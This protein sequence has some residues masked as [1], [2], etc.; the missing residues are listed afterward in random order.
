MLFR[1]NASEAFWLAVAKGDVVRNDGMLRG[2][3]GNPGFWGNRDAWRALASRK[4]GV[5]GRGCGEG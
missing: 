4:L 2:R 5:R 1:R 3:S